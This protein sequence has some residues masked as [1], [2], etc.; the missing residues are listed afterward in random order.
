MAALASRKFRRVNSWFKE[1][2]MV[3]RSGGLSPWHSF[4]IASG[5]F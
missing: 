3:P 5:I 4:L 1:A 2:S